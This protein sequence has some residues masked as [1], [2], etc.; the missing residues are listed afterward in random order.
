MIYKKE[1]EGLHLR[2]KLSHQHIQY[3]T[4]RMKVALATQLFSNSAADAMRFCNERL[5][6][7]SFKVSEATI[8]FINMFNDLF[9]IFNSRSSKTFGFKQAISEN[10]FRRT[11]AFLKE[12]YAYIS[13][14]KIGSDGPLVV[15]CKRKTGLIGFL[16]CIKSLIYLCQKLILPEAQLLKYLPTYKMRQDHIE[17]FFSSIRFH[18]RSNNNST[19]RQFKRAYKKILVTSVLRKN[20]NGNCIP[21]SDITI[22]NVPSYRKPE[23]INLSTPGQKLITE[24]DFQE[25]LDDHQYIFDAGSLSECSQQIIHFVA[26][27]VSRKL[28][29]KLKCLDCIAAL[30]ES[31]PPNSLNF[32][33]FKNKGG[34]V[35]PSEDVLSIC[36][37]CESGF[38]RFVS[39][40]KSDNLVNLLKVIAPLK[41][42]IL[43]HV[44]D[45]QLFKS[46][47]SRQFDNEPLD[48]H[49]VHISKAIIDH[50]L[51]T[52]F[53]HFCK[54]S[55][56]TKDSICSLYSNLIKFKNQ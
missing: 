2:N 12:A 13:A 40:R 29:S 47:H 52:R 11:Y 33:T 10:N 7:K 20:D 39:A 53:S 25:S 49:L 23:D 21:L 26:G 32:I 3:L 46:L 43:S 14:L 15:K 45:K 17:L 30:I 34:L 31:N 27:F 9:D 41:S 50:Y 38:R 37:L 24:N 6:L 54:T 18:G 51:I 5:K 16:I 28:S 56:N 4:Q 36:K 42:E 48:N 44:L 8:R 19:A 35:F 1:S 22:L 55:L